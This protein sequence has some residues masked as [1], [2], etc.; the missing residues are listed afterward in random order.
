MRG[1]SRLRRYALSVS[2]IAAAVSPSWSIR[3]PWFP[4]TSPRSR[5][6]PQ[7]R[8]WVIA[9][10]PRRI[11][12]SLPNWWNERRLSAFA[13]MRA[14][15]TARASA[16][17]SSNSPLD[18]PS[19][20]SAASSPAPTRADARASVGSE[21]ARSSAA[22]SSSRPSRKWPLMN[23]NA[24]SA[25]TSRRAAD[26]SRSSSRSKATRRSSRS[27]AKRL[28][29]S[30]WPGPRSSTVGRLSECEVVSRS[31]GLADRLQPGWRRVA[32]RRTHGS[33]RASTPARRSCASHDLL[34]RPER[35]LFAQ[36]GVAL[37]TAPDTLFQ[38]LNPQLGPAP[39]QPPAQIAI[40]PFATFGRTYA[41]ALRTLT[42]AAIGSSAVPGAQDGVQ[43]QVQAQVEPTGLGSSPSQALKRTGQVR[44]RVE[45]TLTGRVQ[46]VDN[47]SDSLTTR[48][49][50]RALRADAVHHA[51]RSRCAR[52]AR[53]RLPR[54]ARD[55]RAR[56]RR[57]LAL[58]RA[59]GATRRKALALAIAREHRA[60]R[61]RRA[62][63]C[64]ARHRGDVGARR[65]WRRSHP[66]TARRS[67]SAHA[68]R[69]HSPA[70]SPLGSAATA[71]T[72]AGTA[73]EAAAAPDRRAPLW[74][75]FYLDVAALALSGLDL[76]AYRQHRLLGCHQSGLE[77]DA[78][79]VGVHVLRARA[80]V[81]RRD[82]AA[83][84][85]PR[86]RARL[87]REQAGCRGPRRDST[88]AFLLASISR[89]GR[90]INRGLLVVG[91]LLAFGVE[92]RDLHRYVR[93]AGTR[94]RPAHPRR[95]RH[96]HCPA[97]RARARARAQDR[98]ACQG[99][100]A[101]AAV[102]HSYA[103][104]G[105][106][107]QDTFGIDPST[108][109]HGTRLRDSCFLGG[110]ARADARPPALDPDGVLVSKE[111]ISDYSLCGRR[112]VEAARARPLRPAASMSCRSTSPASSRSSRRRR[113]DSFMVT[114][115]AYLQAGH[116]TGGPN[117]SSS[118]RTG[119]PVGGRRSVSLPRRASTARPSRNI[120]QQTAAD[121]Q[122]DHN[123]RPHRHQPES[124][125][126]SRVLLAAAAMSLF[127]GLGF[128][129][130]RQEFATMA[131]LGA[132]LRQIAAFLW[133][134]GGARPRRR[135]GPRCSGSAGYL[136]EMHVAML[137]HVF[138]PPPDA[139]AV[140]W[141]FLVL[142]G[143]AAI[144]AATAAGALAARSIRRL[145]IGETLR[146]Q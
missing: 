43:W 28:R 49:R 72:F 53:A 32:P 1:A 136:P 58:L 132:S 25:A 22:A 5:R 139:L 78:V 96:R 77:P 137:Q 67:R 114:N 129:E 101:S 20:C 143:A 26:G 105:P 51:R 61:R 11:C 108:F 133:I 115:L 41:P 140:P 60:R 13:S 59:R 130:R 81:D 2:S 118:T 36:S 55:S 38:P 18:S 21:G 63:R 145:P 19:H 125:A 47:L 95:R 56:D 99:S 37:V 69:S 35:E 45:R 116:A 54:G 100:P 74:Q 14:E 124:R 16:R 146:E 24:Q 33:S 93:P 44:R 39:A 98:A 107:L 112:P 84:P 73:G 106:D 111:T 83:R 104:V 87:G 42:P 40:M 123:C 4:V 57:D 3:S 29:A 6:S 48:C 15:P 80:A 117:V 135:S 121:G 122:L 102:D 109:T 103:Y 68:S 97:G 79:V 52:R 27:D 82:I 71:G 120:R 141:R 9:S 92:G 90:A 34:D 64:G 65:R 131:A 110:T 75:R 134:G 7:A 126:P 142:L 89:R 85:H 113:R 50:R 138:D 86:T 62:H 76:V 46:F 88:R 31:D 17:P 127:V 119:D 94:R 8:A 10:S 144:G 23:Q 91:L 12:S 30:T 66:W 70:R 128:A